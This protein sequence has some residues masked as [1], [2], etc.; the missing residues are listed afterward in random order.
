MATDSKTENIKNI[1]PALLITDPFE[2]D[3]LDASQRDED[4]NPLFIPRELYERKHPI[5]IG[6]KTNIQPLLNKCLP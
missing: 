5:F 6:I 4:G 3:V 1:K 2:E